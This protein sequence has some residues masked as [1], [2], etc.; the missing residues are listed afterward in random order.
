MPTPKR[1]QRWGF[2]RAHLISG[3]I[4]GAI[5]GAGFVIAG[6][7]TRQTTETINVESPGS[8]QA[9]LNASAGLT[10]YE[11]YSRLAPA[12]VYVKADLIEPVEN[13]FNL[14]RSGAPEIS[15]GSGFLVDKRGD[16]L[17]NY[18]VIDG[19]DRSDGVTVEFENQTTRR[20]AVVAIDQKDDLAVLHVNMHGVPGVT[21]VTRGD[22]TNVE[23][24]D[25]T[26]TI[27]NPSGLDRTLTSGTVSALQHQIEASDGSVITNVIELDQGITPGS[28]GGP[29]IDAHGHV[30]G[31]NSQ[32]ETTSGG[33]TQPLSFAI[34]IDTADQL[35]SKVIPG[36]PVLLAYL[37][38][39]AVEPSEHTSTS[40]A[41]KPPARRHAVVGSVVKDGP[42][43]HAGI[44]EGDTI[45]KVAGV[46]V[47]SIR[48]V[49]DVVS[50]LSPGQTV[51]IVVRR[52]HRQKTI[53]VQLG[54]LSAPK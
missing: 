50:T 6:V 33:Q 31:V 37:G 17:T 43:A 46:P 21:P 15:T 19:A 20:A 45:E 48:Q 52:A 35:L 29:L 26:L 8:V 28:S 40:S 12:V 2:S 32:L 23:V 30:I 22:S 51:P 5:V 27:G 49:L 47:E 14:F 36:A 9:P 10:P 54:S 38:V 7:T 1:S 13:P 18:H 3:V 42:A 41:G 44:R 25:P 4:G 39:G 24:G 34:P 11:I 16:I 53:T